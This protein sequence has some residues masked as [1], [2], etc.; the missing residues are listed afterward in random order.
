M[1]TDS[2]TPE[3]FR[4]VANRSKIGL[5]YFG[6]SYE[7]KRTW[8]LASAGC[9]IV[10][11]KMKTKIV[12]DESLMPF[13]DYTIIKDDFSDLEEKLVY[14]LSNDNYK[15]NAQ[16][17]KLDYKLNHSPEKCVDY[18]FDKVKRVMKV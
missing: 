18:Y 12:N 14:L 8:E 7:T 16:K 6:N 2:R 10:M 5:N 4:E 9:S 13:K 17:S 15:T 1:P 11:P 3:L